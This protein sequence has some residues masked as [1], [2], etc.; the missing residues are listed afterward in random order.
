M[1]WLV[2]STAV[3]VAAAVATLKLIEG[4]HG[5]ALE[6][7]PIGLIG[8][9]GLIVIA[10][11]DFTKFLVI[12]LAI[13]ATLDW[14]KSAPTHVTGAGASSGNAASA[15]AVVFL[16]ASITWFVAR[17]RFIALH[18]EQRK[19]QSDLAPAVIFFVM[20]G[21]LSVLGSA[22]VGTSALEFLRI[23]SAATMLL[24]L[25]RVMVSRKVVKRV[26]AACIGAS[27]VPGIVAATQLASGGGLFTSG[28]YSR[29]RGT[30]VHPNP[31]AIFLT[32]TLVISVGM[33][34]QVRG[35]LR[36]ALILLSI[37]NAVALLLTYTRTGWFATITAVFVYCWLNKKLKYFFLAALVVLIAMSPT[38]IGRLSNLTRL[39]RSN[40]TAGNSL[41]WRF[42][43]W[44][45]ILPLA[46]HNPVTGIG[47]KMVQFN[48][49][50]QKEPHNDFIRAYVETGAIGFMA[51]IG[52][53]VCL[54][55]TAIKGL[56]VTKYRKGFDRAVATS[57]MGAVV[58][59]TM[60]SLVSNIISSSV[61][62]WY[63]FAF[64]A[65]AGV[66]SRLPAEE[67]V[68]PAGPGP[69][70]LAGAGTGGSR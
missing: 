18:P 11:R 24:V 68:E 70:E 3:C 6:I 46:N 4:H 13:R 48:A 61:L 59:F 21:A 33:L 10:F 27:L 66:V 55:R 49:L 5:R 50:E 22:R 54:W 29:I 57:F 31:Y 37:G 51:Y 53:Q 20:A 65:A 2:V 69:G 28:G 45:Q 30:F 58:A 42:G 9:V 60:I 52:L 67:P 44:T 14:S 7:V 25:E 63:F 47:L 56:R 16:A 40:G 19:W 39:Q 41:I 36:V 64:A 23:A 8:F 62:L 32:F 34:D 1:L 26:I 35:K 12:T 38:I 15:L 17:G 43:Y